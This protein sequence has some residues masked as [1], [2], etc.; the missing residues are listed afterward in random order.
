MLILNDVDISRRSNW[1]RAV[2]AIITPAAETN[3]ERE[4]I[5]SSSSFSIG[6]C[7]IRKKNES[8][9]PDGF[10]SP[11]KRVVRESRERKPQNLFSLSLSLS[12]CEGELLTSP[13]GINQRYYMFP[14]GLTRDLLLL[15]ASYCPLLYRWSTYEI[16]FFIISPLLP[17][18]ERESDISGGNNVNGFLGNCCLMVSE[19]HCT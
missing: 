16:F 10:I 6:L 17:S 13:D 15:L 19:L 11:S 1:S 7:I 3:R 5:S 2:T 9:R 12:G 18:R 14:I 4:R 8:K